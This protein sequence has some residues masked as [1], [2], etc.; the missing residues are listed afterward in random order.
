MLRVVGG[1][2]AADAGR[3]SINGAMSALYE[4]GLIGNP[5]LTGGNTPTACLT[6]TAS[7][8]ASARR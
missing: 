1:V 5:Q 3:V 4:L 6:C 8:L 2:Y 7:P